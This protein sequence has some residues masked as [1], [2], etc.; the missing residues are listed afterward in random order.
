MI[1][2]PQSL[3]SLYLQLWLCMLGPGLI[4]ALLILAWYASKGYYRG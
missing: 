2:C 4:L 1:G 3:T